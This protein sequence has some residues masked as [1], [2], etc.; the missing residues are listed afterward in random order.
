MYKRVYKQKCSRVYRGRYKLGDDPKIHDVALLSPIASPKSDKVG[1]NVA[2][3]VQVELEL[4]GPKILPFRG[5]TVDLAEAVPSW[6]N[7]KVAEREGFEPSVPLRTH[8]I[9][10]HAHS[11]TLP[12]L[13]MSDA[14]TERP[15]KRWIRLHGIPL[16]QT[17]SRLNSGTHSWSAA[18]CAFMTASKVNR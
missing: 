15:R 4:E 13:R 8:M 1:Q 7:L 11:T 2:K 18:R 12:P 6:E 10:N 16:G 5:E 14:P 17:D 3:P 9:S